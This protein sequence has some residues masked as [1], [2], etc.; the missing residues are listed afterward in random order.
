MLVQKRKE[1][2]EKMNTHIHKDKTFK[3]NEATFTCQ[4]GN[5]FG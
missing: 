4:R 2:K 3:A 1:P 5:K